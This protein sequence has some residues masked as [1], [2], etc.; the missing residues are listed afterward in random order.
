MLEMLLLLHHKYCNNFK[1]DT[2]K[3]VKLL[4]FTLI[5]VIELLF[6]TFKFDILFFSHDILFKAGQ[7]EAFKL[8]KLP[9]LE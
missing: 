4:L 9:L 1:P 3:A 5:S 7:F 6:S 8:I 2:S